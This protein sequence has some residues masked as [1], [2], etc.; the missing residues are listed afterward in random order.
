MEL[1]YINAKAPTTGKKM[2]ERD[3]STG[4]SQKE[5]KILTRTL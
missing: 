4:H 5:K 3:K 1:N 2:N